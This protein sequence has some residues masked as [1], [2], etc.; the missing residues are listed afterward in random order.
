MD[1][2]LLITFS[3][4]QPDDRGGGARTRMAGP[5]YK[6]G[7]KKTFRRVAAAGRRSGLAT[8]QQK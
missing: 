7:M 5:V 4:N 2:Y 1:D 6:S 8:A 3:M